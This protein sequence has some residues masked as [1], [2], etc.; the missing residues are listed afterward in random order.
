MWPTDRC[1]LAIQINGLDLMLRVRAT[2]NDDR[3]G[4]VLTRI[5][6]GYRDARI[7]EMIDECGDIVTETP[8]GLALVLKATR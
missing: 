1:R 4:L 6:Q 3:A 7:V 5:D 8:D 2:L